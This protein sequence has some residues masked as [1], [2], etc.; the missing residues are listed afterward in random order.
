MTRRNRSQMTFEAFEEEQQ[1]L[2]DEWTD[3]E[4]DEAARLVDELEQPEPRSV[5]DDTIAAVAPRGA[6]DL[7]R[8]MEAAA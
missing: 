7:L 2:G 1:T 5:D 6:L 8:Q 3:E 4:A